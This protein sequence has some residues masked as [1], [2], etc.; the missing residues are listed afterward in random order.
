M[1]QIPVT[2]PEGTS[3]GFLVLRT[4]DGRPIATG[5]SIQS[6][7]GDVVTSRLV[8]RFKDGSIDD[9]STVY[10]QRHFLRLI[11]D[12][13]LQKGP[14]YLHPMDVLIDAK[15][16]QVVVKT[17]GHGND[18]PLKKTDTYHMNL[19]A[20]LSNGILLD[21]L[22]NIPA[23][24]PET[25]VSYLAA[26]P[27]PRIVTFAISN[28]GE[29]VF[30]MAGAR[31]KAVRF[32]VKTEIGGIDGVVAPMIGKQPKAIRVWIVEGPAPVFI[33]MQGPLFNGGPIWR[34]EQTSPVSVGK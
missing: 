28:E 6:V 29:D 21:I 32:V 4:L 1:A 24:G 2:Q 5:D 22:T 31:H 9:D 3:H 19:P 18:A 17:Y 30:S 10:S 34:I 25:K 7:H 26:T 23:N 33:K 15:S 8:F 14:R 20:D 13:H 11:S 16:G 27:K 12:H